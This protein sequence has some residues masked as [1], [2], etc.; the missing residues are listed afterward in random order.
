MSL[1]LN[2]VRASLSELSPSAIVMPS[3]VILPFYLKVVKAVGFVYDDVITENNELFANSLG[4]ERII[5]VQDAEELSIAC[6]YIGIMTVMNYHDIHDILASTLRFE[7]DLNL[8]SKA[9]HK[10]ARQELKDSSK[11]VRHFMEV[12]V[13]VFVPSVWEQ[14]IQNFN[15][16]CALFEN[17]EAVDVLDKIFAELSDDDKKSIGFLMCNYAYYIRAFCHDPQFKE[18]ILNLKKEFIAEFNIRDTR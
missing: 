1:I 4:S 10:A 15:M 17:S 16:S 8:L 7:K 2:T 9:D 13:S 11:S 3:S 14:F 18:D 6:L 5:S 12:G